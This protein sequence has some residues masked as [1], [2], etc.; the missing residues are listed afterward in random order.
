MLVTLRQPKW[1]IAGAVVLLL[2]AAFVRLGIWQL[3]RHE[4]RQADNALGQ[5]RLAAP[6]ATLEDLLGQAG[7]DLASIQYR[8][9]VVDGAFDAASEIL[10]RSQ[11]DLG[12]AGFHVITPLVLDAET[13]VLVNR[14]WVPLTMDSTPVDA[15]PEDGIVTVEGW[16]QL[17]ASR[18]PLGAVEP[19]GELD[20]FNR[21]D[22]DRIGGQMT[23][24]L[25]PVYIVGTGD[26][27]VIPR[28]QR[29]PDFSD[30]GPHLAYAIQWFG[31]ALT[32]LAGFVVLARKSSQSR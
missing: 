6:P 17:S 20:V 16:V 31:F 32:G 13:A 12:V 8:R 19:E 28:P 25:A 24:E 9:V 14:G 29:Q 7:D 15:A 26:R 27:E 18:P 21:V 5:E 1:I 23:H 30:D 4:Q 2:A 3:D 11:V 10:I 22:V